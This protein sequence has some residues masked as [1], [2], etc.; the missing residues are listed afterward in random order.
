MVLQRAPQ[1]AVVWGYVPMGESV[2]VTKSRAGAVKSL[3]YPRVAPGLVLE[4]VSSLPAA[5]ATEATNEFCEGS[6]AYE[7]Q[8]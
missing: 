8:Q 1:Q 2:V 5:A 4:S 7:S 3:S 6:G